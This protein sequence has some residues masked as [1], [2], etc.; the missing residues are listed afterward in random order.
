M[1]F[2]LF[3][4][5]WLGSCAYALWR[6]GQPERFV[7]VIFLASSPLS[8]AAYTPN[9]WRGVQWGILTVDVVMLVLMLAIAFRANRYWPMGIA[10]MQMLQVLGHLIKLTDPTML[11]VVYWVSAVVWAYPMLLLLLLGTVR[12]HNRVKRLGPEPSWSK[13]S[14][15]SG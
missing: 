13:S 5:L 4:F 10:A 2:F 14:P 1:I 11:H 12:H 7:A 9:P 8:I 3:A 15:P 6:G